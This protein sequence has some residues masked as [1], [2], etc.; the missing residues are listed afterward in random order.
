MLAGFV[1]RT[2]YSVL[3]QNA[4][5]RSQNPKAYLR[6]DHLNSEQQRWLHRFFKTMH[7][8]RYVEGQI[9]LRSSQ[10]HSF[11]RIRSDFPILFQHILQTSKCPDQLTTYLRL[12]RFEST[13]TMNKRQFNETLYVEFMK[14]LGIRFA[15]ALT[16]ITGL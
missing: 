3:T 13:G 10:V 7:M 8:A 2:K 16:T 1:L 4:A 5:N 11:A 9:E 15:P 12:E 14:Q 6:F